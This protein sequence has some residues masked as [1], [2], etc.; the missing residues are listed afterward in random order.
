MDSFITAV[1][2]GA[3][4]GMLIIVLLIVG[5]IKNKKGKA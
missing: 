5:A 3:G 1:I 4:I 2:V